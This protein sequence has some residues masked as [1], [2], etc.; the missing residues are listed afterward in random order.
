MW[1]VRKM[2]CG[3]LE[4]LIGILV[5][6]YEGKRNGRTRGMAADMRLCSRGEVG[7]HCC[8]CEFQH[9]NRNVCARVDIHVASGGGVQF[10]KLQCPG[11]QW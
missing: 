4:R 9:L 10:T 11:L 3:L 8:N 5:A 7:K 6:N 2:L 1:A